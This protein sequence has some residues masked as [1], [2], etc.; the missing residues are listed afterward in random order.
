MEWYGSANC[1]ALNCNFDYNETSPRLLIIR[2]DVKHSKKKSLIRLKIKML[3]QASTTKLYSIF[4]GLTIC[5]DA[6]YSS[7]VWANNFHFCYRLDK[8]WQRHVHHWWLTGHSLCPSVRIESRWL[9][10]GVTEQN[11]ISIFIFRLYLISR[12]LFFPTPIDPGSF[13]FPGI[14]FAVYQHCPPPF[15]SICASVAILSYFPI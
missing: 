2:V 13:P 15:Y 5:Y 1:I 12:L 11:P 3:S 14:S 4:V 10:L 8:K 9:R 7:S 6:E